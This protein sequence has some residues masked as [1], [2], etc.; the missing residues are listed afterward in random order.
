MAPRGGECSVV[1]GRSEIPG[2]GTLRAIVEAVEGM[3][4]GPRGVFVGS[5][6]E[7]SSSLDAGETRA[8]APK[9]TVRGASGGA[10]GTRCSG[11]R[12]PMLL[13]AF[14]RRLGGGLQSHL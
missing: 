5:P 8:V 13:Q 14:A 3:S 2:C 7:V 6:F 11:G 10:R 12:L 4:L 1:R 9:D